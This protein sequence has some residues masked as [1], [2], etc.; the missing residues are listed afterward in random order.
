MSG[1]ILRFFPYL[2]QKS[3]EPQ[4]NPFVQHDPGPREGIAIDDFASGISKT[5]FLLI[6][7]TVA[8]PDT[9]PMEFMAG[10]VG[11]FQDSVTLG[12]RPEIGWLVRDDPDSQ[13]N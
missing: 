13:G 6:D 10:F 3:G 7:R 11:V 12:L 8:P 4:R 5:D 1:W 2:P 9:F